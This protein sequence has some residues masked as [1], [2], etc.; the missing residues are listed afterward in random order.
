MLRCINDGVM[1][2]KSGHQ[3]T[4]NVCVIWSFALFL[5]SGRIYIWRTPK[6]AYNLEYLAPTAKHEGRFCDDLGS[7]IMVQSSVGPIITLH[8]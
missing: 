2:I 1:T 4:G 3:T 8:G 7:T 6:E 5:T